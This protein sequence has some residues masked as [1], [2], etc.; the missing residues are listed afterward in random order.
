L[1]RRGPR[2]LRRL[3]LGLGLGCT[4]FIPL[5]CLRGPRS[6]VLGA[7]AL[8][9]TATLASTALLS[10]YLSGKLD[11]RSRAMLLRRRPT[12]RLM[13]VGSALVLTLPTL[14]PVLA[15]EVFLWIACLE[16]S[17]GRDGLFPR[18]MQALERGDLHALLAMSLL[19]WISIAVVQ[20]LSDALLAS[21]E[22]GAHPW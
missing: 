6:T 4:M 16:L 1:R 9:L 13:S 10:G 18:T 17:S 20:T 8:L 21:S 19:S 3:R 11:W 5:L 7:A 15:G 12:R 22:Q 2:L 14:L